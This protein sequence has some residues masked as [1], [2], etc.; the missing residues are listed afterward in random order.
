[1][2]KREST[3]VNTVH[4]KFDSH[5]FNKD[6]FAWLHVF[7]SNTDHKSVNALVLATNN[8]LGEHNSVVSMA[9][10]VGNPEFL[11][12]YGGRID[13][14][15]LRSHVIGCSGLHFGSVVTISQFSEAETTHVFKRVDLLQDR[16]VT[17]S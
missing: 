7:V 9:S 14:E 16:H 8:S 17:L 10:S 13:S 4:S 3:V 11:G 1:M 5:V 2:V 6:S 15:S 12:G